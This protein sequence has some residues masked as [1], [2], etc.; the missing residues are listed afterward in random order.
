MENS[1]RSFAK[2]VQDSPYMCSDSSHSHLIEWVASHSSSS[3][4]LASTYTLQSIIDS[5]FL[6]F[7]LHEMCPEIFPLHISMAEMRDL[8]VEYF[9][10][11]FGYYIKGLISG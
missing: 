8:F 5:N 11:E 4:E 7:I 6:P 1:T 10:R 9:L 2:T 3:P